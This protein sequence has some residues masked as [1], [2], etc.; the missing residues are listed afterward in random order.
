MHCWRVQPAG[1]SVTRQMKT[2]TTTTTTTTLIPY[3]NAVMQAPMLLP[4]LPALWL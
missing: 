2:T 1:R 4:R 3:A